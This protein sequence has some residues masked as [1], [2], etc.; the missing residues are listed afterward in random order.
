MKM[1]YTEKVKSLMNEEHFYNRAKE[2]VRKLKSK[3]EKEDKET[4]Y[5]EKCNE[6]GALA[7]CK[8]L[9]KEKQVDR[10]EINPKT[11]IILVFKSGS[12]IY[13]HSKCDSFKTPASGQTVT[14]EP[15]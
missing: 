14:F 8:I 10:T 12:L 11:D 6:N 4:A 3:L 1:Y 15:L 2:W 7:R 5:V 13:F 9:F